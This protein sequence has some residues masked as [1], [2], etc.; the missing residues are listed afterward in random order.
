MLQSIL[1]QKNIS[2]YKLSKMSGVPYST[3]SDI[4][5]G[6]TALSSVTVGT[7]ARITAALGI[8]MDELYYGKPDTKTVY[9]Y[10]TGRNI[11]IE[12]E[13]LHFQFLGP[14]NLISFKN[15]NRIVN[16]CAH[17]NTYFS[18]KKIIYIEEE[19]VDL[20]GEFIEYGCEE[21]FPANIDLKLQKPGTSDTDRYKDE[22]LLICDNM[23]IL[24]HQTSTEDIEIEVINMT[25]QSARMVMRLSDYT[26]LSSSMSN[27]MQNRVLSIVKRNDELI[28]TLS[29]EGGSTY[30]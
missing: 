10:N 9:L 14:K 27:T 8:T 30:A 19:Y 25:R 28:T 4:I 1:S 11:H 13:D 15:V 22:A 24:D 23:A 5:S 20:K 18:D 26:I 16:G 2:P 21:R 17:I 29:Q 6:H 12:Y 3:L 7:L